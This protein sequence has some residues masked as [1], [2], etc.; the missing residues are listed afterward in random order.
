MVSG[1][2]QSRPAHGLRRFAAV[3]VAGLPLLTAAAPPVLDAGPAGAF[4]A[5]RVA[6]P[7]VRQEPDGSWRLWYTGSAAGEGTADGRTGR[8]GL[9]RSA[10]GLAWTRVPGEGTGGAILE[11]TVDP[12]RFDTGHIAV[13]DLAGDGDRLVLWYVGGRTDTTLATGGRRVR[14]WPLAAV[15]AIS[16]DGER[17]QRDTGPSAGALLAPGDAALGN[18]ASIGWPQVLATGPRRFLLYYHAPGDDGRA[19][20]FVGTSRDGRSFAGAG[21]AL[22]PGAA[23]DFDADGVGA[24]HVL[25]HGDGFLMVYEGQSRGLPT[26]IG[27][28]RSTDGRRF[29]RVR[30]PLPGG[31]ILLPDRDRQAWDGGRVG[32]PWLVPLPDGR[33]RLYY[34]GAPRSRGWSRAAPAWRIGV[35]ESGPTLMDFRRPAG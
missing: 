30:G 8:V 31:A 11:P 18:P 32:Q 12:D 6:G 29:T 34:S 17:F 4:D 22:A 10:D 16:T 35:A 33:F 3:C 1:T 15:R 23:G 7:M 13:S 5:A 19:T 28:A 2:R 9:A 27:L 14:G 24:R 25:P 20:V 26:G 21:T